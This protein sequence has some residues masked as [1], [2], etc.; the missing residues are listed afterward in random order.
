M[1][2]G[3]TSAAIMWG[4]MTVSVGSDSVV[5]GC[6]GA[7]RRGLRHALQAMA[8]LLELGSVVD[9]SGAIIMVVVAPPA[10]RSP[11]EFT[12]WLG[13]VPGASA[14]AM[15]WKVPG[16]VEHSLLFSLPRHTAVPRVLSA[17][18][19]SAAAFLVRDLTRPPGRFT[20]Y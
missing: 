6:W 13:P 15:P 3:T 9:I 1:A 16:D 5:S 19:G 4:S 7:V 12:R 10:G 18:A 11:A 17:Q 8:P 2:S 14:I 20:I